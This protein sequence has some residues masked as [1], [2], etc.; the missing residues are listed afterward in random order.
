MVS[1]QDKTIRVADVLHATS[2]GRI[3]SVGYMQVIPLVSELSDDR[4]VSPVE[5]EA[6]VFTSNYGTLGFRNVTECVMIV[7]CHAGYVV[8]RAAQDHAMAHTGLIAGQTERSFDTAMCIQQTQGGCIGRG[9][10]RMMILPYALREPALETRKQQEY[11]RLWGAIGA[12][13]RELGI[14]GASHLEFFLKQFQKELDVFVAEFECV[15]NQ[16]GVIVL[17]D[18][19]VIGIERAP[20][21]DY[22]RSVWPCLIRE[23]YGSLAIQVARS[24]GDATGLPASRM[25]LPSD[26]GSLEELA[27]TIAEVAEQ[28]DE[29]TRTVVRDL[30]DEPLALTVDET[31]SGLTVET[32]VPG[33]FVG[34]LVRDG[35]RIVYASL[36]ASKRWLENQRWECAKPFAI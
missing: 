10:Y 9:N 35:E 27:T 4:F 23:C 32:L 8:K 21:H 12:F 1:A 22:W 25:P 16:V 19:M 13:N 14:E 24:K 26:L 30:L 11:G 15:P 3:Q 6:E 28:E 18:D 2:A 29:H 17:I 34:Q 33:R 31:L 36:P 7:P 20:S 5:G